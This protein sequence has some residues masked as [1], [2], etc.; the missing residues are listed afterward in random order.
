MQRCDDDEGDHR[1]QEKCDPGRK[2]DLCSAVVLADHALC[3]E[4]P[5]RG[6][7]DRR[8]RDQRGDQTDPMHGNPPYSGIRTNAFPREGAS[9]SSGSGL[10]AVDL[11]PKCPFAPDSAKTSAIRPPDLSTE[12]ALESWSD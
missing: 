8:G 9:S 12:S 5:N 7:R 2:G 10:S 11:K 6:R 1:R 3:G 4:T